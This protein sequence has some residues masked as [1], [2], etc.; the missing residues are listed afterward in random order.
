MAYPKSK[1][2]V[3]TRGISLPL[4]VIQ[5]ADRR[6]LEEDKKFSQYVRGLILAD[7]EKVGLVC[8]EAGAGYKVKKK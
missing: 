2:P 6:C 5:A 3:K 7:L 4:T 1:D 8:R